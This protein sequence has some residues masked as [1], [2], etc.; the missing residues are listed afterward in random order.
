MTSQIYRTCEFCSANNSSSPPSVFVLHPAS[1]WAC[2]HSRGVAR[3]WL[4]HWNHACWVFECTRLYTAHVA[5]WIL[6]PRHA[7]L[8]SWPFVRLYRYTW[9]TPRGWRFAWVR[10]A[11]VR[12]FAIC[13]PSHYSCCCFTPWRWVVRVRSRRTHP[14]YAIF[15]ARK[16][17]SSLKVKIAPLN[18]LP[19]STSHCQECATIASE[20]KAHC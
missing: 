2:G 17:D 4:C 9:Q 8:Y 3:L 19:F 6:R 13:Q 1:A 10:T 20:L 14:K 11:E 15:G 12:N 16:S 7:S 18:I 5:R